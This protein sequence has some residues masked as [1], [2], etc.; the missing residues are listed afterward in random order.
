MAN[1]AYL[2]AYSGGASVKNQ[3]SVNVNDNSEREFVNKVVDSLE[4]KLLVTNSQT[5]I[6]IL[7]GD[8]AEHR[9]RAPSTIFL[10]WVS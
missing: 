8:V 9:S 6:S 4:V 3:I 5:N 2:G 7:E 10:R 1:G